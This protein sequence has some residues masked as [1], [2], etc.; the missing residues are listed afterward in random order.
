MISSGVQS[1]DVVAAVVSNSVYSFVLCLACLAVGAVWSS[2]SCD[3]GAN[4]ILD[5]F[6]QV[7]PKLVFT[8]DGY[9]Y[10]GKRIKLENKTVKW[11][12]EL[13]KCAPALSD[14]VVLPYSGTNVDISLIHRGIAYED[15]LLRGVGRALEFEMLPF[16]HPAFILYSSGTGV[17]LKAK[18]DTILQ[19][20]ARRSDVMFQYTTTSWVMWVLNFVN[21]AAGRSM[22]LYDGSPF[23]PTPTIL[24]QLAEEVGVGVFGTSPRYL[25]EIRARGILPVV[26]GTPLLPVYCGEIQAKALGMAVDVFD[27]EK[28]GPVSIEREGRPGELVCTKPFPSQP[29]KFY[30][31]DGLKKYRES[32][33]DRYGTAVWRQGDYVRRVVDTGGFVFL[34]RSFGSSEIYAVVETISEIADSICVGQRRDKDLDERV[35]LFVVLKP[36]A[37]LTEAL[38]T[39]IKARIREKYSARHVPQYIFEVADIPYTLS[40]KKC[41]INV[42]NIVSG[43]ELPVSGTVANPKSLELYKKYRDLPVEIAAVAKASKI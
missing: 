6:S 4:A 7:N 23:H 9:V 20:D 17:L 37:R 26:G 11:A 31:R 33:F 13:G 16:S 40:G 5:R 43:R 39:K 34:G 22:L 35:L 32:Y 29:L 15:F 36:P 38:T 3:L 18:T 28:N 42:K 1:G 12:Q 25:S 8:D 2:A 30:G 14:V 41:E 21:I 19:H 10:A 24:L 27:S